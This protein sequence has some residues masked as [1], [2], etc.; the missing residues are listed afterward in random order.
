MLHRTGLIFLSLL[1][2][3]A[4]DARSAIAPC[5]PLM[6]TSGHAITPWFYTKQ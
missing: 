3:G 5:N 2:A 4:A 1:L 6:P